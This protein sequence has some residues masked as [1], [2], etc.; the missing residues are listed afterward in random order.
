MLIRKSNGITEPF[1][2]SKLQ[3]ILDAAA[4]GLEDVD[5]Y[6]VLVDV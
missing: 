4:T 1:Q 6:S 5:T 3:K 2:V